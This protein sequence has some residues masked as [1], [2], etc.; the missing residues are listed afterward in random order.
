V[1][2]TARVWDAATGQPLSPPLRHHGW[3]LLATFSPDG[4][5]VATAGND[6]TARVWDAATGQP[7]SPPL[8]HGGGVRHVTFSPDGRRL[9]TAS[10]DGAR[11]WDVAADDRPMEDL[12]LLTRLLSGQRIDATGA[13]VPAGL[14]EANWRQLRERQPE[15][16][17]PSPAGDGKGG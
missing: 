5:R 2:K 12:L 8:R 17:R 14:Q 16:F 10:A 13:S 4:R 6:Q 15:A 9:A 3:V 1:D 7:L 11:V